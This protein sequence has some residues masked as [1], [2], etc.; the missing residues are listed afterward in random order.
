LAA[1][2][3][4]AWQSGDSK[5]KLPGPVTFTTPFIRRQDVTN[6]PID[7]RDNKT[8]AS[9]GFKFTSSKGLTLILNTIIPLADGGLQPAVIWTA[10]LEYKF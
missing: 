5:L 4:S 1:D 6:I 7:Q 9:F 3:I 8:D 2:L 10:G